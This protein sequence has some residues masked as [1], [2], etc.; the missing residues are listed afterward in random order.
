MLEKVVGDG[1]EGVGVLPNPAV[2]VHPRTCRPG[3]HHQ[4]V[5]HRPFLQTDR[6]T[7]TRRTHTHSQQD[8]QRAVATRESASTRHALYKT[9]CPRWRLGLVC[10]LVLCNQ[11]CVLVCLRVSGHTDASAC[12]RIRC[13]Q[14]RVLSHLSSIAFTWS[15]LCRR[16]PCE[17]V[18]MHVNRKARYSGACP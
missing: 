4:T 12:V 3:V 15:L 5:T 10:V 9:L 8:G 11:V 17:R 18:E 1:R 14:A 2:Y 6:Q 7:D 13:K 16:C